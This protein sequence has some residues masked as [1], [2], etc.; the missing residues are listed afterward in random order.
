M[1]AACWGVPFFFD[2]FGEINQR[3]I[4]LHVLGEGFANS[5]RDDQKYQVL[6]CKSYFAFC[7]V[8]VH[9]KFHVRHVQEQNRYGFALGSVGLVCLLNRLA[10]HLA[11]N[12]AVTDE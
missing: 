10:Y 11:F 7:R 6:V 5:V 1:Q 3:G 4:G 2:L 12:G 8:N 9:I